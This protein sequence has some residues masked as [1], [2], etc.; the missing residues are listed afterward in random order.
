MTTIK[1][2]IQEQRSQDTNRNTFFFYKFKKSSHGLDFFE[3]KLNAS[4]HSFSGTR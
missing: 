4:Y 2:K 3:N 1:C